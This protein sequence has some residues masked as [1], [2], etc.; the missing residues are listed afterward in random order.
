M[1]STLTVSDPTNI[2]PGTLLDVG[3]DRYRVVAV[4]GCTL[5]VRPCSWWRWWLSRLA[6]AFRRAKWWLLC[7]WDRLVDWVDEAILAR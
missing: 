5:T 3:S 2:A 4:A 1:S 6:T 7:L